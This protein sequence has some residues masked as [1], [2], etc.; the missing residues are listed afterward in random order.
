MARILVNH[1]TAIEL[2][3]KLT[4]KA[5][6]KEISEPFS[7]DEISR[8]LEE[9]KKKPLGYECARK[10]F[11]KDE[12]GDTI[13]ISLIYNLAKRIGDNEPIVIS[14]HEKNSITRALGGE[15]KSWNYAFQKLEGQSSFDKFSEYFSN[16]KWHLYYFDEGYSPKY[17]ATGGIVRATLEF[18]SFGQ[19]SINAYN[20]EGDT[21]KVYVGISDTS[22][23]KCLFLRLTTKLREKDLIIRFGIGEDIQ[24]VMCGQ[25]SNFAEKFYAGNLIACRIPEEEKSA[26]SSED[27]PEPKYSYFPNSKNPENKIEQIIFKL[28][29]DRS[30]NYIEMPINIRSEAGLRLYL[31]LYEQMKSNF[32]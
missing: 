10:L 5:E 17:D 12:N 21:E 30:H 11:D 18:E 32:K 8:I 24:N 3:C 28:L 15:K 29:G 31:P 6:G 4:Y 26:K 7:T 16:S 20:L 25:Y 14:S 1:W 9:N 13:H 22:D 27:I 19:V 23:P 2:V